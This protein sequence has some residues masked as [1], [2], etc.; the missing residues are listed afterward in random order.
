M[1][2]DAPDPQRCLLHP[3]LPHAGEAGPRPVREWGGGKPVLSLHL[4]KLEGAHVLR[5]EAAA[6]PSLAPKAR[7]PLQPQRSVPC[8]S[9]GRSPPHHRT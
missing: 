1:E 2:R 8:A 6:A 7:N 3:P 4:E 5:G 9:P